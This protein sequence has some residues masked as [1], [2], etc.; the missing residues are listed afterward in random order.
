MLD[1]LKIHVRRTFSNPRLKRVGLLFW[2]EA[3]KIRCDRDCALA[4]MEENKKR[5]IQK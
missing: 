2:L 5:F 3:K 4:E 1:G